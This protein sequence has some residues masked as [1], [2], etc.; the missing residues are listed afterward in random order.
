M[1]DHR[2]TFSNIQWEMAERYLT[3]TSRT[4]IFHILT[5]ELEMRKVSAPWVL[6]MLRKDNS[7][8]HMGAALETLTRYNEEGE[9][10]S[11]QIVTGDEMWLHYW[12][13]ECKSASM[14]WKT[15]DKIVQQ[16]FKKQPSAT[17]L[18]PCR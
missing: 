17:V 1:E 2:F 14:V 4:T 3:Q 12:M 18:Q 10:F 7:R 15:T 11:S 16:K 9:S 13:L 6:R 8:N 5:K